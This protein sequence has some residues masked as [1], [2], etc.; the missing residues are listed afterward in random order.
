MLKVDCPRGNQSR[1]SLSYFQVTLS[2]C[3][4]VLLLSACSSGT[5]NSQ[6]A[7]KIFIN[8]KVYTVNEEHPWA[9]AVAM[10][11]PFADDPQNPETHIQQPHK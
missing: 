8:G 10:L 6:P 7:D 1:K 11:E 2:V 5:D 3:M 4:S 9:E